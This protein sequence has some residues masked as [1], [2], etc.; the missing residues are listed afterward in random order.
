MKPITVAIGLAAVLAMPA[1]AGAKQKP[2]QADLRTA[3]T[4]CKNERGKTKAT[5]E[6]FKA[7]YKSMSRCTRQEAAEE[8]AEQ[9]EAQTNAAKECKAERDAIGD[10]AFADKYGTNKN[11]RNALGKCVSAKARARKAEMDAED[12]QA[13]AEFKNAAKECASERT[14]MRKEAFASKYG[15]NG[16]RRNAFGKCVSS[17]TRDA[18]PAPGGRRLAA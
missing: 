4:N 8:A 3:V 16:N 14:A 12:E 17:K 7:R 18:Q 6:A 2:D 9:R 15:T 1:A 5:R 13:A 10:Q 11:G